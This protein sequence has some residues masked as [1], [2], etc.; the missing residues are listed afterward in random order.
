MAMIHIYIFLARLRFALLCFH[1]MWNHGNLS[2]IPFSLIELWRWC[3]I[4]LSN[5]AKFLVQRRGYT[6]TDS[7]G[8]AETALWS[9]EPGIP[10]L[11][12]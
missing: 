2:S 7:H 9:E 11:G 1:N 12:G 10:H 3:C 6:S 5:T 8:Q 4:Y